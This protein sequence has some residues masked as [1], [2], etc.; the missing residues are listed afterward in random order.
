MDS[1]LR[2]RSPNAARGSPG[3]KEDLL[4]TRQ[5]GPEENVEQVP[6]KASRVLDGIETRSFRQDAAP[7]S[8]VR[9]GYW[10]QMRLSISPH[11]G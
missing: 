11:C 8:S 6:Q 3:S 9:F 10:T 1:G 5:D 4:A 2:N 7:F